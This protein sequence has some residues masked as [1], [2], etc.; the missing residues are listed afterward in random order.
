MRLS[1]RCAA[2]MGAAAA[3]LGVASSDAQAQFIPLLTFEGPDLQAPDDGGEG[4]GVNNGGVLSPTGATEGTTAFFFNDTSTGGATYFDIGTVNGDPVPPN[5]PERFNNWAVVRDAALA[6]EA[7]QDVTLEFD[8]TYDASGMTGTTFFQLGVFINSNNG[9]D[10]V[11][12][13]DLNQGNIGPGGDFP[14][15]GNQAAQGVT[16]T[17]L[18]PADFVNDFVG[19][20]RFS[21][22]AGPGKPLELGTGLPP[23]G[24]FDFAQFGFNRNGTAGVGPLDIAF[25]RVGFNIVP[26]PATA[27]LLAVAGLAGLARRRRA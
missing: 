24:A 6:A 27:G 26:E 22:P 18:D 20:L 23:D 1:Y 25:D 19:Q 9:F 16:F 13:G 14:Q 3:W 7:G 15:P 8:V 10:F 5:S 21:V 11:A 17:V 12:F 2:A 4:L